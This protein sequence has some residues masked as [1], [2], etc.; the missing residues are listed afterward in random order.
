MARKQNKLVDNALIVG[1]IRDLM[2]LPIF[3]PAFFTEYFSVHYIYIIYRNTFIWALHSYIEICTHACALHTH[4]HAK[5]PND[6]LKNWRIKEPTHMLIQRVINAHKCFVT[7]TANECWKKN[8][9]RNG[10]CRCASKTLCE[11]QNGSVENWL[12][13]E[14]GFFF[15]ISPHSFWLIDVVAI[16]IGKAHTTHK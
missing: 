7:F 14:K 9:K 4:T 8:T 2:P 1:L 15:P 16:C 13:S 12:Q 3:S 6:K 10:Y 11:Y 5:S